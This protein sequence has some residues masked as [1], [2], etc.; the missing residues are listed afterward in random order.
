MRMRYFNFLKKEQVSRI[1]YKEPKK[2][3]KESKRDILQYSIGALLYVPA[4]DKSRIFNCLNNNIKGITSMVICLEDAIGDCGEAEA[5]NNLDEVLRSI[6]QSQ[7][8]DLPLIFIRSRSREQLIKIKNI[9]IHN[10]HILTGII[11]PKADASKLKEFLRYLEEINCENLY[12][13]PIIETLDFIN[14]QTKKNC[15]SSLYDTIKEYK[16][17]ILGIRIGVTDI[18]GCY[19]ARRNKELTIY[20]NAIFSTFSSDILTLASILDFEMPVSG[21]VSEFYNMNDK[22]IYESYVKENKMDKL[23]GF[24]GKTVINPSQMKV[25]QAMNVVSFEDYNDAVNIVENINN[26][27]SISASIKR[28]RMNEVNPHLKWARRI[29]ALSEVFGVLNE[30]VKFDELYE[31]S[32]QY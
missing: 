8:E 31:I 15:L 3:S 19:G 30:G 32:L 20:D 12:V 25:V 16:N 5:I 21:S 6:N 26:K 2:F 14:I 11:V 23:N 28:E 22:V 9:L 1:F 17:K 4:I 13:M 18:L 27:K 24:I 29:L 7:M 10:K